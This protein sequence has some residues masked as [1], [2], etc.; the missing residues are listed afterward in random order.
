MK[1]RFIVILFLLTVHINSQLYSQDVELEKPQLIAQSSFLSQ[2]SGGQQI[3]QERESKNSAS[4]GYIHIFGGMGFS[5][6]S[7]S[8]IKSLL[9]DD[10]G[11]GIGLPTWSYGIRG[12]F[13]NIFQVEYNIGDAAHDF[14]NNSIIEDVP[15][16][17]IKMDYDTKDL[18]LKINPFFWKQTKN[19]AGLSKAYFIVLGKG[20]VEW[21]DKNN[22]GFSGTS[23][24][25]G[26]EYSVFSKN[27][28]YSVSFK[29]YGIK[30]DKTLL[31]N[32]PI[33]LETKASDYI[34]EIK[35]GFGL[36]I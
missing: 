19:K 8:K 5:F 2:S 34:L 6:L 4:L 16:E 25:Y 35:V 1:F 18:Q 26:L 30:F 36:G 9:G 13:R 20:D 29:R 21:R 7:S 33:D 10:F 11:I 15:N 12:G 32:I 23:Q 3:S 28:S 31:F 24:I 17:I 27:I 14:N 22:D